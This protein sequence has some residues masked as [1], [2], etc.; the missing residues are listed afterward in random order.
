MVVIKVEHYDKTYKIEQRCR[1]VGEIRFFLQFHE[2]YD[3]QILLYNGNL[4][5]DGNTALSDLGINVE[6]DYEVVMRLYTKVQPQMI[7]V[8]VHTLYSVVI[9]EISSTDTVL[10]LKKMIDEQV[11]MTPRRQNLT[12]LGAPMHDEWRLDRYLISTTPTVFVVETPQDP[13]WLVAIDV[14]VPCSEE[15]VFQTMVINVERYDTVFTLQAMIRRA[16]LVDEGRL[17]HLE[18]A[19]RR[20]EGRVD[21]IGYGIHSGETVTVIYD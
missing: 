19:G 21:I 10:G 8:T 13:R 20:L 9:L 17:F 2:F 6:D 5:A 3:E 16:G 14:V 4:L 7:I 1:S 11:G 12:T 15:S 18:H